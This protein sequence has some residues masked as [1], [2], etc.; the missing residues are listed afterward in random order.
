MFLPYFPINGTGVLLL[1]L[2]HMFIYLYTRAF[3]PWL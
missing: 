3:Q 2:K 1:I